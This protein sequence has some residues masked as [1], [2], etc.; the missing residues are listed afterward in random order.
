MVYFDG[1]TVSVSK[2]VTFPMVG[3]PW[4]NIPNIGCALKEYLLLLF[5]LGIT[6]FSFEI[7]TV[8]YSVLKLDTLI[9]GNKQVLKY[10]IQFTIFTYNYIIHF[11]DC[12]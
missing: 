7:K 10:L 11:R 4:T 9:Q 3:I 2:Y 6:Y 1:R 12:S 8:P 5:N